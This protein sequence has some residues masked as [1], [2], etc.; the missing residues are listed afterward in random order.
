MSEDHIVQAIRAIGR[1]AGPRLS[2]EIEQALGA[3]VGWKSI[4]TAPKD[5][6]SKFLLWATFIA[7]A[8]VRIVTRDPLGRMMAYGCSQEGTHWMPLP[9][10]PVGSGQNLADAAHENPRSYHAREQGQ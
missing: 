3:P 4:E 9:P 5:P 1:W 2:A 6:W 8:E 10:A 7:G